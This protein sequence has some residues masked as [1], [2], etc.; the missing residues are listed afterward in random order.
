MAY[1]TPWN[2]NSTGQ[3]VQ[4]WGEEIGPPDVTPRRLVHGDLHLG[5]VLIGKGEPFP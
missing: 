2:K 4:P 1:A 3:A 5:N